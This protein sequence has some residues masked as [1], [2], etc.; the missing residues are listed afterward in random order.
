MEHLFEQNSRFQYSNSLPTPLHWETNYDGY[1]LMKLLNYKLM[2]MVIAKE[3]QIYESMCG[4]GPSYV[5]ALTVLDVAGVLAV[6]VAAVGDAVVVVVAVVPIA[7]VDVD[8]FWLLLE[9][10]VLSSLLVVVVSQAC[11]SA[12]P[13]R[14]ER[15]PN[16]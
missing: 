9:S 15:S 5:V 8:G 4:V 10:W 7:A 3:D 6:I 14:F 12:P 1:L 2:E 16:N 11:E 13:R